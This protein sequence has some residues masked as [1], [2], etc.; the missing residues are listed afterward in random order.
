M[1][2]QQKVVPTH[3][4]VSVKSGR[5]VF[6]GSLYACLG[7]DNNNPMRMTLEKSRADEYRQS[8]KKVNH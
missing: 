8:L 4:V 2:T 5:K 7:F 6:E 3:E 1:K